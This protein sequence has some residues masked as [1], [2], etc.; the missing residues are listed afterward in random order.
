MGFSN[1]LALVLLLLLPVFV[2]IGYSNS[3]Y[4][5]RRNIL[6]LLLRLILVTLIIFALAGFQIPRQTDRLAVVFMVDTSDSMSPRTQEAALDYI[7]NAL[8]E[9][10]ID[11]DEAAVVFFG[12]NAVVEE[13]MS[14]AL[15]L[16][17]VGATP[18]T[19]NT[20]IDE[21]IRLGLAL[22]PPDAAK[23]MVILSD[24]I[25]TVGDA[26]SAARLAATTDVQIT[27]VPFEREILP[28]EVL[29]TAVD[30]PPRVNE[31]EV[32]DLGVTVESESATNAELR[33]LA[34]GEIIYSQSV[35]LLEG[36]NR[37]SVGPLNMPST[38]FVDFRVQI[39]PQSPDGFYQNN[40][41]SAFTEVKGR[42]TVL[43]VAN[44]PQEIEFLQPA[45]E[46]NGIIVEVTHPRDLPTGLAPLSEY[47]SIVLADVPATELTPDRMKLLQIYVRDLGGGLVAV[48][49]PNSYGVGGYFETPLEEILPVEMRIRD[50]Q[51]IPTLTMLFV[52]D[53]SGSMEMVSDPRGFTNL[54]L[55]KEAILR[56][57]N[58]MNDFDRTGVISF[59]AAAY[60]IIDLQEIGDATSRNQ[61]ED[62]VASL[63]PG[64]GTD[65]YGALVTAGQTLPAD[66]SAIKHMILLTDGG[67]D[68]AQS[69]TLAERL[70]DDYG[71]TLSVVAVG[72]G[73]APWLRDLARSGHG[74][75]H[76]VFDVS[77]IPSIFSA[78]TVLA[79]RSY[80]FEE[81]F[82]PT[83][84]GRSPIIEGINST[85]SLQGYV[86]TTEKDT[87]TVIFRTPE[88]DP[89]LASW[90]YGLGR[91]VAFTSDA[92]SRW[93]VNWVTWEEYARFW[94]QAVRWTITEG[95]NSNLEVR[96]E[97]R[98]EQAVLVVDARDDEGD[99]LNGVSLNAAVV[100]PNLD[101]QTINIPQVAPGRYEMPFTPETEGAY[102]VRVAGA[103]GENAVAQTSG[104]VLSY[105]AEYALSQADERFL[106]RLA[107][108]TGGGSLADQ[109]EAVFKH[110]LSLQD[111]AQ[112][113]WRWL[114]SAAA[115]LL[116]LDIAMRRLIITPSDLRAA[117]AA[118]SKWAGVGRQLERETAT[119][120]RMGDLMDAKKRA[121]SASIMTDEAARTKLKD[122]VKG[123][124]PPSEGTAPKIA[125]SAP[126][127]D[128]PTRKPTEGRTSGSL[129]S[130]LL[131][132]RKEDSDS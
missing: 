15:D 61:L 12:G 103:N 108:I 95:T 107:E 45:L 50:I 35:A 97:Q 13:P 6:S 29:V 81:E 41:L 84:T 30:L 34:G 82:F 28:S 54:E 14:N 88:E 59:D 22:F 114:L 2:L 66:P 27:Y 9:L 69:L 128:P 44:D 68:P 56:S 48:G 91:S 118:I 73:Y 104:W 131:E 112:P 57:F 126:K 17:Q 19:L 92:S 115:L 25:E 86:A 123:A 94:S 21:A 105:S 127:S 83:L 23:R 43:L 4:R 3:P 111:S 117:R 40:E 74:N 99:F 80:I 77:T 46:E 122:I 16:S 113:I 58:F 10:K 64:G 24:G 116:I 72:Q 106:S 39:E 60:Y 102:F 42:P 31:D 49:G 67:A 96:V 93:G 110:N 20:D 70:Y 78:E 33:V 85:P 1:P 89:L 5:R 62:D 37:F 65:I 7:R 36:E 51:R 53:R 109:P 132:K 79:T 75:F 125:P 98:G 55:A 100:T 47:S 90:Q 129:A 87:A 18:I 119:T 71:I 124:T 32:F 11:R 120:G 8:D 76:E 101:S 26:E 38:G 52:L 130:R 63:R 121:S